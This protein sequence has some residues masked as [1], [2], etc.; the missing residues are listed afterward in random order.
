MVRHTCHVEDACHSSLRKNI[1]SVNGKETSYGPSGGYSDGAAAGN[2]ACP[3]TDIV[4]FYSDFMIE[5]A[6]ET[7]VGSGVNVD[8][9]HVATNAE[10]A[11]EEFEPGTQSLY[12]NFATGYIAALVEFASA[13]HF[14]D[15]CQDKIFDPLGVQK[16]EWFRNDL[17]DGV[18]ETLPG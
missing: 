1:P 3:L 6:T 17:P 2:P 15:Y 4:G 14:P 12:S 9:F 13:K 5:E 7:S 18:L 16:T 10:G 8:W 11:W